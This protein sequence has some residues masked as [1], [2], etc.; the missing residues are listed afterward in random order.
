MED[1]LPDGE[2]KG[3]IVH[4]DIRKTKLF[5]IARNRIVDEEGKG[6]MKGM[7]ALK[8]IQRSRGEDARKNVR[9]CR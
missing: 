7:N 8:V 1:S 5:A 2:H 3:N 6:H 4:K 9:K